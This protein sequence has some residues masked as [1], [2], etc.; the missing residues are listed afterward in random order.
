MNWKRIGSGA[1]LAGF[2]IFAWEV[3]Q[4]YIL[5]VVLSPGS[6]LSP[7]EVQQ[8]MLV[9]LSPSFAIGFFLC[10]LY[11]LARPR[12]GPGPMTALIMGSIAWGL[13]YH[14]LLNPWVWT[15]SFGAM[16]LQTGL[17]WLKY[18]AAMYLAGWQYMEKAP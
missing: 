14:S 5:Q 18:I 12:L 4:F 11:A 1:A 2:V 16:C 15:T 7:K 10:W 6:S 9:V 13:A 3:A 17:S 8:I